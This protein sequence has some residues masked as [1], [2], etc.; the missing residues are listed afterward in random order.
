MIG[1]RFLGII[2]AL[3]FA[4]FAVRGYERRRV[5]RL[6]LII[7]CV[8]S[9]AIVIVAIWPN[10]YDP[11]FNL[12]DAR[13]GNNRRL[14]F[15]LMVGV[16]VLFA[17]VLR[18]ES[19]SD[20]SE[21]GIRQLVE[22]LA[23][24]RFDWEGAAAFPEAPRV[25]TVSPA[26][27]EAENVGA[28]MHAMPEEVD[29]Y[30]VI[31]V[32]IDDCSDDE[33]SNAARDAGAFVARLPIRRGGGLAIRVGYEIALRLGADIVV[34]LDADGQ[35]LP[36][37]LPILIK[38]IV[39]D[40]ADHVNGSRMLGGSERGS[41]I[42][43]LGVHFFSWVVTLLT[44]QRVTDISSGYRATRAVTLQNLILEQDQFWTSEV[45][46][47]ALRQHARVVEVPVTFLT[48]R[49][50]E[51]KKPKTFRYAWNFTKAIGKTWLR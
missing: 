22:A 7:S 8:L 36:E 21:R 39:E 42:R 46:I 12:F 24:E 35:H 20:V 32:V 4:L 27:N 33:T 31:P 3:G 16:M 34:T 26:Y 49:G 2:A 30:Q 44:G 43:H 19:A 6:N 10:A 9:L 45:T 17:L 15:L 1:L 38:P 50:G 41:R 14:I 51:S 40:Q 11:L 48:R 18:L 5:S 25:V 28:V 23:V 47:E 29:G 37:E 13:E